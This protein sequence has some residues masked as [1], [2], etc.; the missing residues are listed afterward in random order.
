MWELKLYF[1]LILLKIESTSVTM[2]TTIVAESKQGP[3]S[4]YVTL[5]RI[6]SWHRFSIEKASEAH[7]HLVKDAEA[8]KEK[9]EVERYFLVVTFQFR[10]CRRQY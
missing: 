4:P 10:R 2:F 8:T 1:I 5:Q 7:E 9:L 3:S 6:D